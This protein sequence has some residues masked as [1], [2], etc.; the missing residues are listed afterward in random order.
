VVVVQRLLMMVGTDVVSE[1][2]VL[3]PWVEWGC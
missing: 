2:V 1:A 3:V